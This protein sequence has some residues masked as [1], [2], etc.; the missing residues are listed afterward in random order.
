MIRH[1]NDATRYKDG[2]VTPLMCVW[3]RRRRQSAAIFC[4][5]VAAESSSHI[6]MFEH[7]HFKRSSLKDIVW[8]E[9]PLPPRP[10][11]P[12]SLPR[13]LRPRTCSRRI[14][15]RRPF[16]ICQKSYFWTCWERKSCRSEEP[17]GGWSLNTSCFPIYFL[18]SCR[19]PLWCARAPL[20]PP[21]GPGR[22]AQLTPVD[23]KFHLVY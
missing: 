15:Q 6:S 7:L 10:D 13:P 20:A 1:S 2:H 11:Q 8:A 23:S 19:L 4:V 12:G 3:R 22:E 14:H 17:D 16:W 18:V 5:L 9:S 21:G